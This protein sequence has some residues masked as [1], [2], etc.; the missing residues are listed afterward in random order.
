MWRPWKTVMD[1]ASNRLRV[2]VTD[3]LK[4]LED[5]NARAGAILDAAASLSEIAVRRIVDA[6]WAAWHRQMDAAEQAAEAVL[7]PAQAAYEQATTQAQT[8]YAQ[9]VDTAKRAWDRTLRDAQ[10]AEDLRDQM[11]KVIK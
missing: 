7:Q 9:A 4:R 1:E 3:A 10:Q 5:D 8:R 6:A 11:D 2:E